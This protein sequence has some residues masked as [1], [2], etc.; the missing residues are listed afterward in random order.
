MDLGLLWMLG[1]K[2]EIYSSVYTTFAWVVTCLA[3]PPLYIDARTVHAPRV[4]LPCCGPLLPGGMTINCACPAA[5]RAQPRL[6]KKQRKVDR[7]SL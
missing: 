7:E 4:L 3:V 6:A 5:R 2:Q 1:M